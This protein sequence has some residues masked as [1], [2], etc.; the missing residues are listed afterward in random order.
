MRKQERHSYRQDYFTIPNLENSYWAG[1]IAAD[2][3]V[4]RGNELRIGLATKD[5][6]H[7]QQFQSAVGGRIKTRSVSDARTGNKYW[8]SSV[9]IYSKQIVS[10]LEQVF[11][12]HTRK[13]LTHEPPIG[14]TDQQNFAYLA[15]YIDGDG[16]YGYVTGTGGNRRPCLNI[17]GTEKFL[18]WAAQEFDLE[19]YTVSKRQNIFCL[20]I[21]GDLAI[22]ARSEYIDLPLP[23]L[24]RKYKYWEKSAVDLRILGTKI[25]Q[26]PFVHGT[27]RMYNAKKCRCDSCRKAAS[28][29]R[30]NRR[31]V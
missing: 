10:D 31:K 27:W 9:A 21:R 5:L 16:H 20:Q 17:L 1:F 28:Q 15:G 3:Y 6:G 12:I 14:L 2:G 13:S 24:H 18:T 29:Y 30:K 19:R 22:R 8:N 26:S 11:N 23:M 4:R 7:I 25:D